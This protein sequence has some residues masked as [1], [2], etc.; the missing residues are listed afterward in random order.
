MGN[1]YI[2]GNERYGINYDW[3]NIIQKY[4]GL[5]VPKNCYDPCK[6]PIK[7]NTYFMILSERG[8]GKTT[9]VLLLG[10][11]MNRLY[12]TTVVYVRQTEDMCKKQNIEKLFD[13]IKTYEGGRYIDNITMG[14]YTDVKYESQAFYFCTYDE[15]GKVEKKSTNPF[16]KILSIDRNYFYKSSLNLPKGDIIIFDEFIGKRYQ[17]NEFHDFMDLLSTI[18]RKRKSA[19]IFLLANTISITSP[20]FKEFGILRDIQK[21]KQN[22]SLIKTTSL[23]TKIFFEIYRSKEDKLTNEI[24]ATYFGFDN[25][26]LNSITGDGTFALEYAPHIPSGNYKLL[27]DGIYL[28]TN[29]GGY[30]LCINEINN[31][32]PCVF[33]RPESKIRVNDRIY[34]NEYRN[35]DFYA[36]YFENEKP[37]CKIYKGFAWDKLDK[38]ILTLYQAGKF[39]YDATETQS[40]FAD[41]YAAAIQFKNR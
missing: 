10:M 2:D 8:V 38:F 31:L 30:R 41:Y 7:D 20:Y 18:I 29:V 26:L 19:K 28:E 6:L 39:F 40:V 1:Y 32:G 33:M 9:N 25:P 11:I 12:G 37:K 27:Y 36:G 16:L 23:G 22:S 3:N 35:I 13:V 4:K 17:P 34:S 24:N 15:N 21:M 14:A 5:R